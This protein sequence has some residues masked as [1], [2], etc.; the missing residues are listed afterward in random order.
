MIEDISHYEFKYHPRMSMENRAAQFA[1]FQALIGYSA[2][3]ED[4]TRKVEKKRELSEEEIEKIN[5]QLT[6]F[7]KEQKEIEIMYFQPD[8]KKEGGIYQ[9][10][11][12]KIKKIDSYNQKIIL[13][14]NVEIPMTNIFQ[15]KK[16]S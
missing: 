12:S 6:Y 2:M 11:K 5:H 1:P 4:T 3:I 16:S 8:S 15:I 10:K 9:K 7:Y 13:W 14:D